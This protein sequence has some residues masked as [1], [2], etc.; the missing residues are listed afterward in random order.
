MVGKLTWFELKKSFSG[1][2]FKI[3]ICVLL[4]LN[5]LLLGGLQEF[6]SM[7]QAERDGSLLEDSS[8]PEDRTFFRYFAHRRSLTNLTRKQTA[9]LASLTAEELAAFENAMKEK[10]GNEILENQSITPSAAMNSSPGYFGTETTD[11]V[12]LSDYLHFKF[13][14]LEEQNTCNRVVKAAKTFGREAYQA[15]DDYS[16]RRNLDIIRLYSEP[17]ENTT[18]YI[19]GWDELFFNAPTMLLVFLLVLLNSASSFSME[20]ERKTWLLL[21]TAKNGKGKTLAAKYIAGALVAIVLTILFWLAS[22]G[23]ICFKG[24]LSGIMQPVH[25]LPK[26]QLCPFRLT[27]WQYAL[28][29][30]FLQMFAA[31]LLSIL[32]N[33]ISA[34]CNSSVVSCAAGALLLGGFSYLMFHP[35][36]IEW[37]S[38]PLTFAKPLRFFDSFYTADI[39]DYPILWI[40]VLMLLWIVLSGICIVIGYR[41]YHRKRRKI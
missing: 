26:L 22:L 12:L 30:L 25:A 28:I 3:A 39:F 34:L 27:L 37:F 2:F 41:V 16:L 18:S 19:T 7:K 15:G 36:Y 14:N 5:I 23:A 24:G 10:Y 40:I 4:F 35:P 38:G 29:L 9:F 21:H 11:Y 8:L 31:V 17:R 13:Q 1:R 6:S 20:Q 32:F 33:T